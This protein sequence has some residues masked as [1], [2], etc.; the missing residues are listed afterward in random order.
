MLES[1]HVFILDESNYTKSIENL[2]VLFQHRIN[3]TRDVWMIDVSGYKTI[4][5]FAIEIQQI[6]MDFD[7][8]VIILGEN[9]EM[10]D[11]YK[12]HQGGN[13]LKTYV[14]KIDE[15]NAIQW[16]EM[17]KYPRR[18]NLGVYYNLCLDI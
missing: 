1:F 8:D 17:E 5:E 12:I 10:W 18:Q 2:Y 3:H 11:F 15:F 4:D 13:I 6:Q 14:G 7:D 9:G 16:N